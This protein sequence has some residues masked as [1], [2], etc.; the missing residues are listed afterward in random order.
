MLR[1]PDLTEIKTDCLIIMGAAIEAEITAT[2]ADLQSL[3][4]NPTQA[5]LIAR[6]AL[7]FGL[8][9]M[10]RKHNCI[11]L[12]YMR[13]TATLHAAHCADLRA[14]FGDCMMN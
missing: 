14:Y 8:Q 13:R 2:Q 7:D 10:S 9:E 11:M 5:S 4:N 12:E 6:Q 3:A 1:L